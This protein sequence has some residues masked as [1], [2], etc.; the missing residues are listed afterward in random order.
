[1]SAQNEGFHDDVEWMVGAALKKLPKPYGPDVI[2]DVFVAI[3]QHPNLMHN[4]QQLCVN[5]NRATVNQRVG[6][7]TRVL[8]GYKD[9]TSQPTTRTTLAKTYTVLIPSKG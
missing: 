6:H 5:H 2:Q 9:G 1:V 3:E 8:S 7:F 4:Y